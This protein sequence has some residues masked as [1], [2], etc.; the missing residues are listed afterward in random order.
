MQ[1]LLGAD[2]GAFGKTVDLLQDLLGNGWHCEL[3]VRNI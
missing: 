2:D 1:K 3:L